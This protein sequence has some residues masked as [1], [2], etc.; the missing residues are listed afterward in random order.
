V[1]EGESDPGTGV[2]PPD[3]AAPATD[4]E[5]AAW[6]PQPQ[7]D[8]AGEAPPPQFGAPEQEPAEPAEPAKKPMNPVL[9]IVLI[10]AAALGLWYVTNGWVVKPYRIPSASMEPTLNVGDRVLVNRFIYRL[11]DPRRGDIVVFHPPGRGDSAI[12]NAK[13]EASVYY[14][15]RII[16]LPGETIMGRDGHVEICKAPS[17]GC[18]VLK[19]PYLTQAATASDFGPV[20]IPKGRYFMMGDNRAISDDSRDWGTLPRGYIIGEAFATYWPL[21]RLRTL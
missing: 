5:P 10:L 1:N 21:D 19:E 15:K 11:H 6:W 17:V 18:Y 20:Q 4:A 12:K 14:I 3:P 7:P 2:R 13:T 8:G 16:G 9:E